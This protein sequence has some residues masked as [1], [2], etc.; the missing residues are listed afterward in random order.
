MTVCS[1]IQI[2]VP[3]PDEQAREQIIRIELSTVT[4][5]F[6]LTEFMPWLIKHTHGFSGAEIVAICQEAIMFSIEH[7]ESNEDGTVMQGLSKESLEISVKSIKPQIT[8]EMLRYY[9]QMQSKFS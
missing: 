8:I 3:P 6:S 9:Q 5:Q 4:C 7:G 2:Y 1:V